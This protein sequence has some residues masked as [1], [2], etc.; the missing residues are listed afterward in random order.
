[1]ALPRYRDDRAMRNTGGEGAGDKEQRDRETER[2]RERESLDGS[3]KRSK[4]AKTAIRETRS[5]EKGRESHRS[6]SKVKE[7]NRDREMGE[8]SGCETVLRE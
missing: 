8:T 5:G 6:R 2:E 4:Q 3:Q 1:M 7:C